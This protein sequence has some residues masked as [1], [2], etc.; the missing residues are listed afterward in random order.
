MEK[1]F[2]EKAAVILILA[3]NDFIPQYIDILRK[4]RAVSLRDCRI[5][6]KGTK[7]LR[8][9]EHLTGFACFIDALG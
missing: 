1:S 4:L 6:R 3:T 9:L 5:V 2:H 7:P 8:P